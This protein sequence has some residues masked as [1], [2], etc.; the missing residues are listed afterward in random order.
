MKRLINWWIMFNFIRLIA[1]MKTLNNIQVVVMISFL[2][3]L[4]RETKESGVLPMKLHKAL[5]KMLSIFLIRISYGTQTNCCR[6][7]CTQAMILRRLDLDKFKLSNSF[8]EEWSRDIDWSEIP[9]EILPR[10]LNYFYLTEQNFLIFV[11]E[12]FFCGC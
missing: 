5:L 8:L 1:C 6:L 9:N 4:I 10:L 2:K 7:Y 11:S 12:R 3:I